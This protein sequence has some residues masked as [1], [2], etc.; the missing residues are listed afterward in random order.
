LG[1]YSEAKCSDGRG[2]IRN[3]PEDV[4][5]LVGETGDLEPFAPDG[6]TADVDLSVV[7]GRHL[8]AFRHLFE[9]FCVRDCRAAQ[10]KEPNAT[11]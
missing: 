8:A 5:V 2:R 7:D 11:D 4:I 9:P 1:P 10:E 6:A 3:A